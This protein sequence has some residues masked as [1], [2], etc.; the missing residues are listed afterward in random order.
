MLIGLVGVIAGMLA[1]GALRDGR[2]ALAG[3]H[4]TTAGVLLA[5]AALTW[6]RGSAGWLA[7]VGLAVVMTWAAA[8]GVLLIAV[9]ALGL[10]TAVV[11]S[12][13]TRPSGNAG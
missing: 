10:G 7:V 13:F 5:F 2:P 9:V 8:L 11:V 6:R 1:V 4:A 12:L 3:I